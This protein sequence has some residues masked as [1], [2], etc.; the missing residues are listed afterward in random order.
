MRDRKFIL[1]LMLASIL[2]VML[3]LPTPVS[4]KVE[5][6]VREGISPLQQVFSGIGFRISEAL[7][8]LRGLGG[9]VRE[10]Q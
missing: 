9:I 8:A 5:S 7:I 2:L 6:S 4:R 1:L 10:N 3:N